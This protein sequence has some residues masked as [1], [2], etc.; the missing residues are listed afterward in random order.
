[1]GRLYPRDSY[2]SAAILSTGG[3]LAVQAVT[4]H[5]T[6][7]ICY[8]QITRVKFRGAANEGDPFHT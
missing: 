2:S 1:M 4:S 6:P 8:A 5:H 7:V 3:I